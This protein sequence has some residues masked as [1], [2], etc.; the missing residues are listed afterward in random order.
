MRRPAFF[1]WCPDVDLT[2]IGAFLCSLPAPAASSDAGDAVPSIAA[3]VNSEQPPRQASVDALRR[4]VAAHLAKVNRAILANMPS[5]V[6]L[7]PQLA[8]PIVDSGGK[9]LRPMQTLTADGLC[10][11]VRQRHHG[12]DARVAFTPPPP[13]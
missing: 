6:A 12:K 7:L 2:D 11:Y 9:R 5:P 3:P 13:I 8:C 10:G 1:D 4:L